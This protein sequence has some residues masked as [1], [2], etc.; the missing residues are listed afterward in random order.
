MR[1]STWQLQNLK[2]IKHIPDFLS[3]ILF[4]FENTVDIFPWQLQ[5]LKVI[6]D[7]MTIK[8]YRWQSNWLISQSNLVLEEPRRQ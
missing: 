4:A 7:E 8:A 2:K 6:E 1:Q 3:N 5:V